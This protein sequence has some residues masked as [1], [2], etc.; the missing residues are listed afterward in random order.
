MNASFGSGST[1]D[2][3]TLFGGYRYDVETGFYQVRYRYYHSSLGRWV[4]RDPIGEEG[5]LNLY[6]FVTNRPTVSVDALGLVNAAEKVWCVTHPSC[7]CEAKN[8]DKE[9]E[10]EIIKRYPGYRDH[11]VENAVKHCAWM[12]YVTSMNFCFK[13]DAIALG[14]AHEDHSKNTAHPKAMDLH[15]NTVGANIGGKD[16]TDCVNKCEQAA[17]AYKLYWFEAV[18]PGPPRRGL[19]ADFPG[20]AVDQDGNVAGGKVGTGATVAP[21]K[22]VPPT[23]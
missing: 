4:S 3:E 16:L 9:I 19:P 13:R 8:S 2:W 14:E 20:F 1:N 22:P 18:T 17:I 6:R 7:C 11:T 21:T 12:C 23:P 10:A 5:G 15:N